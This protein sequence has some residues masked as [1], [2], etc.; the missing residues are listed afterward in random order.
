MQVGIPVR[1]VGCDYDVFVRDENGDE[2]P[3]TEYGKKIFARTRDCQSGVN[4]VVQS[5]LRPGE[6]VQEH[7]FLDS[8]YDLSR[9]RLFP[10]S[11]VFDSGYCLERTSGGGGIFRFLSHST[12]M[13][14]F[15]LL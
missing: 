3:Q 12:L 15:V 2:V 8:V 13:F 1:T 10:P 4:S 5:R 7:F 11:V 14:W 9:P 6:A